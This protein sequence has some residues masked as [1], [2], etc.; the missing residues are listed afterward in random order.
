M[1]VFQAFKKYLD[2]NVI[3]PKNEV[4]W[5]KQRE[6]LIS[7]SDISALFGIDDYREP[8]DVW[9]KFINESKE[10]F[11]SNSKMDTGTILEK[12][13]IHWYKEYLDSF[14]SEY[15]LYHNDLEDN[16]QL[17]I[18]HK[19]Y[20]YIGG[21][22]DGLLI[23]DD[24][25][26]IVEVKTTSL[27]NEYLGKM[28]TKAL[29]QSG[30]Y[31]SISNAD[32]VVVLTLR[33]PYGFDYD[34]FTDLYDKNSLESIYGILDVIF[35]ANIDV[36]YRDIENS[37]KK[38]MIEVARDFYEEYVLNEKMPAIEKMATVKKV[39]NNPMKDKEIE[40]DNDIIEEIIKAKS[41]DSVVKNSSKE[42]NKLKAK[43]AAYMG[44]NEILTYNNEIQITRKADENGVRK[45]EFK[46]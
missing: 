1:N 2:C 8:Y 15:E 24:K 17:I 32:G 31:S 37:A 29:Y 46:G 40:A 3:L 13:V 5:L 12:Y 30:Y 4:D 21:T 36:I 33:L 42:L 11:T 16:N 44:N 38:Q 22:P 43:I 39:F 34:M 25:K 23:I 6:K 9:D 7:G 35:K 26:Y 20:D 14:G 41:L 27:S 28:Q 10:V 19:L 18:K 45:F